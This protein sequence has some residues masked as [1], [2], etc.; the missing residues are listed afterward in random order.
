MSPKSPWALTLRLRMTTG[1]P[2]KI[3]LQSLQRW[4]ESEDQ[5]GCHLLTHSRSF[6]LRA[7]VESSRSSSWLH[8]TCSCLTDCYHNTCSYLA[9]ETDSVLLS[10]GWVTYNRHWLQ[11]VPMS[12]D[13]VTTRLDGLALLWTSP[14]PFSKW[15][16]K[17]CCDVKE[18]REWKVK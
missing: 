11:Q 1:F 4:Q 7:V 16:R 3:W 6:C 14:W 10:V 5:E 2:W 15:D 18:S 12:H 13:R 9:W 8:W 17:V